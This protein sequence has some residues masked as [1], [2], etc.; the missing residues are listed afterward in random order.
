MANGTIAFDTLQTSGQIDGTARSIDTDYLL[1]GSAKAWVNFTGVT[2]T[3]S[4][5]SFNIS[6]L[7]DEATARTTVSY[8]NNMGNTNYTGSYFQ[9]GSTAQAADS[10]NN[11]YTGA[12]SARTAGN[13]SVMSHSGSSAADVAD[14]DLLIF[15]ELA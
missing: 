15:G 8:T 10:F 13:C 1:N 4:R 14:N 3:A 12:F 6:G 2:T 11:N 5:D 7:T 9:S